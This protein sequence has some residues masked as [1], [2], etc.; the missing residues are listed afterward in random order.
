M[1]NRSKT[2]KIVTKKHMA[3]LERERRQ[4]MTISIVVIGMI[5]FVV[6]MLAYG[7]LDINYLQ[8]KKPVAVVNGEKISVEK[9]QERLQL[10][11]VDLANSLQRYQF[12]QQN[13]GM[14]TS[15]QQQQI[16]SSLQNPTI[17]GQ[18]VL[19]QMIDDIL[20]RQEAKKRGII[21]SADEVER[22]IQ[23]TYQFFP[24][25]TST[26]TITPTTFEYPT[27][28]SKQ[29][30]LYP[31]TSTPTPFMT[32]TPEATSTPDLSITPTATATQAPPT[33]TSVP[34]AATPTSTP[35]TLEGF[36]SEYGK[37]VDEFKSYG[38]SEAT[39]REAYELQLLR[40]KVM[41]AV[42][43][44]LPHTEEQVW[45]RHILV[46]DEP[47]AKTVEG[48]LAQGMDFAKVA[49]EYSTDTGTK[50]K[51]GDLGWF[52][53]GKMVPE[54]EAAAFTQE[55]GTISD[56]IKSQFG[57]HIIQVLDRRELP[58]SASDYKQNQQTAFSDWLKKSRDDSKVTINDIWNQHIPPMP[59]PLAQYAQ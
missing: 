18:Q 13:F 46:A 37:T 15:Q 48:L 2:P 40:T 44:D 52:G 25:G 32:S 21:V 17:L 7:Y 38:I 45:A 10:Q 36:K 54:F 57:Y 16:T 29:L 20:I 4:S 53:K 35:Y 12:Y 49:A 59:T 28:T 51:G 43:A 42:T 23:E 5:T 58:L 50:D 9:W 11:R 3:R 34:E 6:L 19:D 1:P 26:P 8:L 30:T 47:T 24:N 22:S 55:I 14:D 56:P 33:P 41:D 39:L 31:S 27:L